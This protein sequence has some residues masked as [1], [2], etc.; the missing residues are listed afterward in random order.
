MLG[1]GKTKIFIKFINLTKKITARN[2]KKQK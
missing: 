1:G 2:V